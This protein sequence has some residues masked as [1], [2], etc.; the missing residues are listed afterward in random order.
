[1][2]PQIGASTTSILILLTLA[3][4]VVM[5]PQIGASTTYLQMVVYCFVSFVVMHPQIG[6]STTMYLQQMG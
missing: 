1:M 6:A 5:H 2:H 3:F 4:I